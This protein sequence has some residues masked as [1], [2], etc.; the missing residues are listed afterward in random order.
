MKKLFIPIILLLST[1]FTTVN[2]LTIVEV[3]LEKKQQVSMSPN[4][5]YKRI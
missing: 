1:T 2:A 3:S 5:K 4:D